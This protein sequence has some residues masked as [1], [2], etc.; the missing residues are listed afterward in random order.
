MWYL[1]GRSTTVLTGAGVSTASGIPD[2]RGP[3]GSLKKRSPVTISEFLRSEA[4]RRRYWARSCYGWP[5][6]ETRRP[7]AV[8][9]A[10]T[11]LQS[12]GAV[13]AVITQNVDGLHQAAGTGRVLELHGGLAR[14][15]CLQCGHRVDRRELQAEMLRLNPGWME[16]SAEIAPD[17]DAEL[18][19]A[20]TENFTVPSCPVCN[21]ILKPDVVFFGESVPGDRVAQAF[22]AVDAAEVLLVLG[23]SLTVYSGYRFADHAV[24]HGRTLAVVNQGPTRADELASIKLDARL[25]PVAEYLTRSLASGGHETP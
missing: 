13:G 17:G 18:P 3:E 6:M 24:K 20:V 11:R 14:V 9:Y 8:H 23:S 5:F 16:H 21:G 7:N 12:S 1:R 15:V 25:E 4:D 19:R 22:A 10:I 2:Y